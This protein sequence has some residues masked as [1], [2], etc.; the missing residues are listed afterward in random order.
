MADTVDDLNSN[1][2]I[3]TEGEFPT[4]WHR[5]AHIR[6]LERELEGAKVKGD[7][8]QADNAAKELARLS[9]KTASKRETRPRS[10]PDGEE[11]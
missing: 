1:P 6:D 8:E 7:K 3:D 10:D 4:A 11:S 2:K 5:D 9:K